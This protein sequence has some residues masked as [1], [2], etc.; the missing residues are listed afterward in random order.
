LRAAAALLLSAPVAARAA[1]YDLVIRHGKVIDGTGN[2]WFYADL[3]VRDGRI[4]AVGDLAH[5]HAKEDI[6][7]TGLVVAPGFIDVHTHADT[8][9]YTQPTA[10]NFVRDGV[11]T[12]ITGN[13]G[14]SPLHIGDYFDHLRRKGTAVNVGCLIG[15]NTVLRAVKG[16]KAGDLT[17]EQMAKARQLVA[18]AMEEGAVG[19]STGLIYRPGTY[20]KTEEI[21]ELAKVSAGYGGIY[22]THMRSE[23]M[24]VLSAID[25]ALTVGR[26]AHC[27]V[28]ISHFKLSSDAAA[29]IGGSDTTLG[30]VLAARNAGQEVWLDQYP[31]TASSTTIS[32]M[33]PDD[34]LAVGDDAARKQ[35]AS[36]GTEDAVVEQMRQTYEVQRGRKHLGYVVIASCPKH[37]QYDG[38]NLIEV[39]QM[40]KVARSGQQ[41][42]LLGDGQP[43]LPDV[44]VAD[45]CRAAVEIWKDGGA[46]CVF[47]SMREP[48]VANIMRCP[49]VSIASDSGVRRFGVGAPHPRGYGTNTRVLGEYVRN[50]HV[51]TLEDAVRKMTS[52]P[53][54]AFRLKDRGT[55]RVGNFADVTVFN[56]DTVQDK[57][58]F[59]KPHQYPVGIEYV[60]VNGRPVLSKGEM[61]KALPGQ[62]LPGPGARSSGAAAV[63]TAPTA[64]ANR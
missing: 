14:G 64:Q 58:T 60:L 54:L 53:A 35:L 41:P 15:H 20:S 3:G 36:P 33:L 56:P 25:E 34:F 18:T 9:L 42:E 44:T 23:G 38:H 49:L 31:Y 48:D 32:T 1:D 30:K 46:S 52:Q 59:E 63:T 61:T 6:D 55:L 29:K 8:D 37:P 57:A 7:A 26:D 39:A 13:C 62:P 4:A 10:D 2:A 5:D 12:I 51:I 16:D 45:Q 28:E 27:R 50:E 22:A 17:D 24:D 21:V 47:H 11:T 40:M 19:F 43:K